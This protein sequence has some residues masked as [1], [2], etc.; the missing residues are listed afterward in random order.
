M[1]DFHILV[2]DAVDGAAIDVLNQA[3]GFRVSYTGNNLKREETLAAIVDADAIIIRSSTK[4]NA[5]LLAAA[6]QLK[7]IA[8]AGVGV[9]NVDVPFATERKI[10]VMNTPAGNTIATAEHAFGLMLA[11]ARHIPQAHITL[12]DG[13]WDRKSFMGTELR[14]KTLG[15]V[16]F[17]R[18]GKAL[19]VRALAFEMKVIAF[20]PFVDADKMSAVGVGKA[21]LDELYAAS[22]FIS[23]HSVITDETR[24]MINAESI[25]KMKAGVRII[26]A[27]RGAL[28]HEA[29]LAAALNSGHVAGAALDVFTNEPPEEGNPLIAHP[30]IVHTPHLAASTNE[31]QVAVAVE[32]AEL[33]VAALKHG[34][35]S[36]VVNPSVIA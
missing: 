20:D 25:A 18:I 27:A 31:A 6:T 35:Y 8:R 9:D 5:E 32:A 28:I 12:R 3:G 15:V 21:T 14:G 30:K 24:E 19:A 22:D 36:N 11:L 23:L 1:T 34:Q 33:I 16:G 13:K 10:A 4:A 2:P 29:D 7:A 17:G 26:N